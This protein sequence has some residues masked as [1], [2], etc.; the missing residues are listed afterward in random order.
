MSNYVSAEFDYDNDKILVW[1]RSDSGSRTL[2]ILQPP[3][4]FYV[5]CNSGEYTGIDGTKLKKLEFSSERDFKKALNEHAAK[6]ES[7]VSPVARVLMD[8]YYGVPTPNINY[9]FLDIETDYSGEKGFSSPENPYAPINAITIYLSWKKQYL[10]YVVPPSD[11]D[12]KLFLQKIKQISEEKN[13][14]FIPDV[15]IC[16]SEK[17]LLIETLST[18]QDADII[19]GWNS[20]FF[21]NPYIIKRIE[22]VLGQK[23]VQKM[24]FVG[25]KP[26]TEKIL[27]KFGEPSLTYVLHGRTH[28]DYLDVFKK[29]TYGSRSS[30]SLANIAAEELDVPKL[31]YSGTLEELY[32]G[33]HR[34]KNL[35]IQ[36]GDAMDEL[37]ILREQIRIEIEKRGLTVPNVK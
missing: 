31:E 23:A 32:K 17:E 12:K 25:A 19:S 18:I 33:L 8:N 26:P 27:S 4:Y 13:L 2:K 1:E 16:S 6:Y 9:A 15:Q 30:Y 21:D 10:T 28:L 11:I 5:P 36:N 3:R 37:N 29:F 22:A 7:D 14:G 35:N 20:E 24:C 34:P